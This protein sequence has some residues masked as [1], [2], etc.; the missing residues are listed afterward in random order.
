MKILFYFL[1]AALALLGLIF[2][3]GAQG[4]VARMIIGIILFLAAGGMI[5]LA[6]VKTEH[7]T[8]V[9]QIDLSGNVN[10]EDMKCKKCG[11]SLSKKSIELKAGAV[12]INCEYCGAVYQLEEDP[13]W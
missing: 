11:G 6:R 2:I 3:V 13:S 5:Y 7:T 1:S 10:L 4:Q 9:H 8:V 12:F